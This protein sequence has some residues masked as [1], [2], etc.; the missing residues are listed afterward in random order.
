MW[1]LKKNILLKN[2]S[3]KN[4]L[5]TGKLLYVHVSSK[6]KFVKTDSQTGN[7]H[8]EKQISIDRKKGASSHTAGYHIA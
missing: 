8:G 2:C 5:F 6:F 1:V 4:K 3:T 7:F